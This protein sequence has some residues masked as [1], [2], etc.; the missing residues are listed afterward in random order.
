MNEIWKD[1]E[2]YEG[3]YQI[4][5]MGNVRTLDRV[6]KHYSGGDRKVKGKMIK[7]QNCKGYRNFI[8][9]KEG[10]NKTAI[11]SRMVAIAF[12]PNPEH[13]RE[14][15]HINGIKTDNR[16]E[17]LEWCTGLENLKHGYRTGLLKPP[18]K[19]TREKAKIALSEAKSK[20]VIDLQ[21]GVFYKSAKE[22]A[23]LY[24]YKVLRLTRMLNGYQK[25]KTSFI[26]A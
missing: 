6:V 4:S 16:V 21:T 15:N 8:L 9:S 3:Y 22:L 20:P 13:K 19:E 17:N 26:Y 7:L 24:G 1:I 10:K 18:S 25:N 2:G 14:V 11:T 23:N 5:S 12:I